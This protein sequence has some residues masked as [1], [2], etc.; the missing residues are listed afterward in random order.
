MALSI[1]DKGLQ[2]LGSQR[3]LRGRDRVLRFFAHPDHQKPAAIET[4]FFGLP[5]TGDK[6]N[7]IDWCVLYYGAF[8]PHELHLL[9]DLSSALRARGQELNFFDIGAN[10]GHHSLFMSQHA[11]RLFCFEPF[12]QVREEMLRKFR[13]AGVSNATVFPVALG[14]QNETAQFHPPT[15]ANQGTGTL[16]EELPGNA[17]SSTISVEVVRGDDF[18]ASH[19]LPPISLV[20]MDVEG[21][22]IQALEGLQQTIRRDRPPILMEISAMPT[23]AETENK[24]ARVRELLYPDHLLFEVFSVRQKYRLRPFVAGKADEALVLPAELAGILPG[25]TA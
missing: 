11:D 22:E 4:T 18:F 24:I 9:S 19:A 14:A 2:L 17:S 23:A 12:A 21:F 5:Y 1:L 3:W 16:A 25:T 8:S 20:K 7:F 15:G 6:S 13:H 10:I